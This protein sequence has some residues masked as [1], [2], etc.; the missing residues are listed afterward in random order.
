M[1]NSQE[2]LMRQIAAENAVL[3]CFAHAVI[4]THHSPHVLLKAFNLSFDRLIGD[5]LHASSATEDHVAEVQAQRDRLVAE[6][7]GRVA[8]MRHGAPMQ[9]PGGPE[10]PA[11]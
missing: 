5:L 4:A 9:A 11:P 8:A 7:E 3:F 1:N 2:I 6:I 10:K